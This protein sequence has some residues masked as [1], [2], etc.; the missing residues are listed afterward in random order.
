MSSR[1]FNLVEG[2]LAVLVCV[3]VAGCDERPTHSPTNTESTVKQEV[4]PPAEGEGPAI[5]TPSATPAVAA[6]LGVTS[7]PKSILRGK[8]REARA[9][10]LRDILAKERG[11]DGIL[12]LIRV[13]ADA[14][15]KFELRA[16]LSV[17][18]NRPAALRLVETVSGNDSNEIKAMVKEAAIQF[19]DAETIQT[20]ADR[21]DNLSPDDRLRPLL[22]E[23]VREIRNPEAIEGLTRLASMVAETDFA[24]DELTWS[25]LVAL[26]EMGTAASV[27]GIITVAESL[28][29]ERNEGM[30][31]VF[32]RIRSSEALPVLIPTAKGQG[33]D[34]RLETRLWVIPTL[35][36]FPDEEAVKTLTEL[37]AD[38]DPRISKVAQMTLQRKAH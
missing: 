1:A 9:L 19:G 28:K 10:A 4:K 30:K 18:M 27:D 14:D 13:E 36:A 29:A 15:V 5:L 24:Q 17:E 7:D 31:L 23:M 26:A 3:I 38:S 2:S 37:T 12:E 34:V 21:F 16:A 6:R 22:A 8:N 25:A 33:R 32:A 11:I 20:I 35:G